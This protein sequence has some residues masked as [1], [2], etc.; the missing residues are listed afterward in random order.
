MTEENGP[1]ANPD[2]I[3]IEFG[4]QR[5]EMM[6]LRKQLRETQNQLA[7]SQNENKSLNDKLSEATAQIELL[8]KRSKEVQK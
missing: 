3:I 4:I 7:Q 2:D 6:N 5:W 8:T 1:G